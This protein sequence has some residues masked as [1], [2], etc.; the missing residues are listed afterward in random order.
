M[1]HKYEYTH[2]LW[3][4]TTDNKYMTYIMYTNILDVA[5]LESILIIIFSGMV[6]QAWSLDFPE[7]QST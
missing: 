7:S 6:L 1:Q 2:I 4:F 3:S 5:G